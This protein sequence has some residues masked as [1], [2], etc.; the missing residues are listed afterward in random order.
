MYWIA[1]FGEPAES[2]WAWRFGGHHVSLHFTIVDGVLVSAT[3]CFLG[4]DPAT[5]PLL[6]PHLHRPLAGAEELGRELVRSL[7]ARQAEVAIVSPVPPVDLVGVNRPRLTEGDKP[8]PL[9]VIWRGRF[10]HELD[11]ALDAMQ[12]RAE[13]QLGLEDEHLDAVAFSRSPKGLSAVDL[14]ADQQEILRELLGTYVNRVHDDFADAQLAKIAGRR[15]DRLSFMWAG[16]LEP[17]QPHYYRVQGG[18]LFLE[19]DNT[20]R[21]ANHI[22]SVWRDLALDFGGDPLASHYTDTRGH[23]GH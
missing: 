9:P 20:Q 3:P 13:E 12:R 14:R 23:H 11:Q 1:V 18:D 22:H 15:L 16:G 17:D 2:T 7:D 6:G 19:Y 21:D 4:A 8:L 5:A 10:E